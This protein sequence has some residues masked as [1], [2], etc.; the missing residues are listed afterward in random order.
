MALAPQTA[1]NYFTALAGCYL[2][3]AR[4]EAGD[5]ASCR[6]TILAAAGGP[7]LEPV[8]RPFRSRFYEILTR[9][10]LALGD[11]EAA[12]RWVVAAERA[13]EGVT[14]PGRVA[15]G[16]RAR[17]ALELADGR[18]GDAAATALR[19][20]DV[21]AQGANRIEAARAA[22]LAG[23]ALAAAG[24]SDDAGRVLGEAVEE[25]RACGAARLRDAAASELRRLGGRIPARGRAPRDA[26]PAG[27]LSP[28]QL[29]VAQLV[30]AGKSNRPHCLYCREATAQSPDEGGPGWAERSKRGAQPSLPLLSRSDCP[31]ARRR[32]A[33]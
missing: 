7:G 26:G 16:L 20:R 21:A 4:L 9:A 29:E 14:I 28:R 12:E 3:E 32:R 24:R 23:R 11:R 5:P 10:E 17:A 31:I 1:D 15:E 13:L 8:E 6:E 30:A 33:S 18:A 27:T 25:L 2:A 19:A 22:A